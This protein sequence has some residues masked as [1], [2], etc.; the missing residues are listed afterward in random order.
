MGYKG[1][2]GTAAEKVKVCVPRGIALPAA[3]QKS[4]LG[5]TGKF[6]EAQV[7]KRKGVEGKDGDGKEQRRSRGESITTHTAIGLSASVVWVKFLRFQMMSRRTRLQRS[8]WVS[9]I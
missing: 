8:R 2:V 1:V 4:R 9:S 7:M 3:I 5:F 6:V